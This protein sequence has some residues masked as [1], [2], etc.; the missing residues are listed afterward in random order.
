MLKTT[1]KH[2]NWL[3]RLKKTVRN[4][5]IGQKCWKPSQK[6]DNWLEIMKTQSE[7][8]LKMLKTQSETWKLTVNVENKV[9]NLKTGW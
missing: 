3:K 5:E 1:F 8:W 7:T 6:H 2:E 4:L 9:K